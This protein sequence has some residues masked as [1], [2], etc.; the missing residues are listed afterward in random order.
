MDNL[1]LIPLRNNLLSDFRYNE[2]KTKIVTRLTELN[3][4]HIKYKFDNEFIV[5]LCNLIENL[6]EKSDKINKKELL[7]DIIAGL[8]GCTD[9]EKIVISNAVDFIHGNKMIRK[10]SQYKLFKTGFSEWCFKKR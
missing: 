5:L 6:S 3:L 8:F 4:L 9:P 1:S 7:L 10:I 2:V